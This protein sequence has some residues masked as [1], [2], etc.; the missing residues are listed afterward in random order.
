MPDVEG[1]EA[2]F[3][4]VKAFGVLA[5]VIQEVV[6]AELSRACSRS[7]RAT[8]RARTRSA[9]HRLRWDAREQCVR[10]WS[11]WWS[12]G[13]RTRRHCVPT[14]VP[15]RGVPVRRMRVRGDRV[16]SRPGQPWTERSTSDAHRPPTCVQ[17]PQHRHVSLVHITYE[18]EVASR[19]RHPTKMGVEVPCFAVLDMERFQ[20]P[21]LRPTCRQHDCFRFEFGVLA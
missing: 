9:G 16:R 15:T 3:G 21:E 13:S 7:W 4:G 18:P 20:Q 12:C 6:A 11:G 8:A 19:R 2:G 1:I 17:Q 10:R 5:H 14:R